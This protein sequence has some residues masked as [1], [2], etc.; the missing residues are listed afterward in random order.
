[1]KATST[2]RLACT[3]AEIFSPSDAVSVI[4]IRSSNLPYHRLITLTTPSLHL[5][6]DKLS[7]TLDFI[8]VLSGRLYIA[9]TEGSA[10]RRHGLRIVDIKDIPT[11]TELQL[12]CSLASNEL[13]FQLQNGQKGI[14]HIEFVWDDPG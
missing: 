13:I 8:K 1:M 11:A 10:L 12:D 5:E 14:I 4:T 3:S 9:R 6:I 7:I 2:S